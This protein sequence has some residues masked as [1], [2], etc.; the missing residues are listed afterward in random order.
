MCSLLNIENLASNISDNGLT[1]RNS[2]LSYFFIWNCPKSDFEKLWKM[3]Y[4][5]I[6]YS[7]NPS[8]V[9]FKKEFVTAFADA[10][11]VKNTAIASLTMGL[12]WIRPHFYISL[13]GKCWQYAKENN[14]LGLPQN[15]SDI[16]GESYL[17]LLEELCNIG[18]TPVGFSIEA[19]KYSENG[20]QNPNTLKEK[21][22][23]QPQVSTISTTLC[24]GGYNKI[25]YG[26]P[27]CGKS[28]Y[29]K[30]NELTKI[31]KNQ[32]V[33]VDN[34]EDADIFE[35][36]EFVYRTIFH[37][38]Y[39]YTDF[40]GQYMPKNVNGNLTYNFV[41]KVFTLALEK[42]YENPDKNV[43]LVIEEINRGE[44]ASIF[45]DLFQLLDRKKNGESEYKINCE[46]IIDYL[47][48]GRDCK[49]NRKYKKI[50]PI[51]DS[52]KIFIP[53]NLYILATMNTCDQNVFALDTAFKRRWEMEEIPNEFNDDEL[54]KL[55]VPY[56][57]NG[58]SDRQKI[59]TW[60]TFNRVINDKIK[61]AIEEDFFGDDRQIGCYFI[62]KSYLCEGEVFCEKEDKTKKF[63]NKIIEYLWN[64]VAK[65][66]KDAW[67]DSHCKKLHDA[68]D[69]FEN[70]EKVFSDAV[71]NALFDDEEAKDYKHNSNLKTN[72]DLVNN[73]EDNRVN[74]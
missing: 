60:K 16:D 73:E 13:D 30:N 27:G 26:V 72:D 29:I 9:N 42:A 8:D 65:V 24:A 41:P 48:D 23:S 5:A 6:E 34:S 51:I 4:S 49:E 50:D 33:V 71:H 52:R 43:V 66:N 36:S 59:V 20:E 2:Q 53:S 61:E 63:A 38:G 1:R 54:S 32:L 28:W 45:G 37:H 15:I 12:F 55:Y 69:R 39:S 11:K 56:I 25:F 46:E 10:L 19:W 18:K 21:E 35:N 44:A 17:K 22:M 3:F 40:V 62:N 58:G 7:S 68:I 67:F 31:L 64:D 47:K 57:L 70:G 14:I 74:E